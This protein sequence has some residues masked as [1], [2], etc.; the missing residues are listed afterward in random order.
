[1][2]ITAAQARHGKPA[3]AQLLHVGHFGPHQDMGITP[4]AKVGHVLYRCSGQPGVNQSGSGGVD[5]I[6]FAAYQRRS[7]DGAAADAHDGGIEPVLWIG[8]KTRLTLVSHA[9]YPCRRGY[10]QTCLRQ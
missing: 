5:D 4:F 6:A 10:K 8:P 3:A 7:G 1:M 9:G 2:R